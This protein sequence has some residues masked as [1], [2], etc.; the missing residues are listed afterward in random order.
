M[1]SLVLLRVIAVNFDW[2]D[3]GKISHYLQFS[4]FGG[5]GSHCGSLETQSLTA[6]S[7]S[8]YSVVHP[9]LI[10]ASVVQSKYHFPAV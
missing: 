8:F 5:N 6:G 10:S 9:G 1:F 7:V 2:S 4:V 3:T